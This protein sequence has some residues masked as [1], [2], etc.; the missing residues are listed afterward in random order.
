MNRALQ[1][2]PVR[3]RESPQA[4]AA[5]KPD[6]SFVIGHRGLERL[7]H[8]L[9]TLES[10]AGQEGVA[11]ECIVVEQDSRPLIQEHLPAWVRHILA[12]PPDANMPYCRS[13]AFNVGVRA[14]QGPLLILHDG[15][16]LVPASYAAETVLWSRN[17]YEVMNLKRFI[18]YLDS[19]SGADAEKA[20]AAFLGRCKVE[21][22]LENAE[23]GGSVAIGR[24]A[25]E[26]I[27]G[28][29]E[30]FL[31]WG[32]EDNEFWDRC[33]TRRVYPFAYLPLVHLWHE[34]QAGKR[35]A[36]GNGLLTAELAERR[37][38]IPPAARIAELAQRNWGQREKLSLGQ[39]VQA[40]TVSAKE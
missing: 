26:E 2:W 30:E 17:G 9:R 18:F 35:A 38:A 6:V 39:G 7:P 3:F 10:I 12:P 15:D 16:L 1:G 29:D 36:N 24:K 31:G 33:L 40:A 19:S 27:G 28:F 32:G 4:T 34:S 23:G 37:R 5:E 8:I 13:W 14:A 11:L 25:Y 20:G 21:T 22:V